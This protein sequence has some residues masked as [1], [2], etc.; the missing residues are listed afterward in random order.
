[1]EKTISL[2]LIE[3][4]ELE[5]LSA[6]DTVLLDGVLYTARDQAHKK[7]TALM[8]A[9][10][11]LPFDP[12]GAVIYYCGPT[13]VR[14]DGLFGS[15]GPTTSSRMDAYTAPLL[16]AGVAGTIG[17]GDRSP[18]VLAACREFRSVY[19]VTF[20][21]AGAYLAK[22]VV[23]QEVIAFPEL[24]TEAVYR[25]EVRGFPAVVAFDTRGKSIFEA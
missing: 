10:K 6:G 16:K 9:G 1:V 17:K 2:P 22:R 7:L 25:L 15:S 11:P 18:G 5:K 13:P 20:G 12:N 21:G 8:D 4:S 3:R 24:G 19:L 14:K 23:R